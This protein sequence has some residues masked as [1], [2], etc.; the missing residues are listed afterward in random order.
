MPADGPAL[1]GQTRFSL[2]GF[3]ATTSLVVQGAGAGKEVPL[4]ATLDAAG[5]CGGLCCGRSRR[6]VQLRDVT[7]WSLRPHSRQLLLQLRAGA[8]TAVGMLLPR[9]Q[10]KAVAEALGLA[11]EEAHAAA[12]VAAGMTAPSAR[13]EDAQEPLV[14]LVESHAANVCGAYRYDHL[15]VGMGFPGALGAT[16]VRTSRSK[17][18]S[19]CAKLGLAQARDAVEG[20]RLDQVRWLASVAPGAGCCSVMSS[21]TEAGGRSVKEYVVLGVEDGATLAVAVKKGESEGILN[22]LRVRLRQ[23]AYAGRAGFSKV[24]FEPETLKRELLTT[25]TCACCG[26][27]GQLQVTSHSIVARRS[28]CPAKCCAAC[29]GE[30]TVVLPIGE[31]AVVSSVD[32][33][34]CSCARVCDAGSLMTKNACAVAAA[35]GELNCEAVACSLCLEGLLTALWELL[36]L[37][38][39]CVAPGWRS[40]SFLVFAGAG[41]SRDV[42]LRV[43]PAGDAEGTTG[44]QLAADLMQQLAALRFEREAEATIARGVLYGRAKLGGGGASFGGGGAGSSASSDSASASARPVV[45]LLA[46]DGE[47]AL[48]AA[49][50]ASRDAAAPLPAGALLEEAAAAEAEAERAAVGAGTGK[51]AGTAARSNPFGDA[52]PAAGV[53]V[54]VMLPAESGNSVFAANVLDASRQQM[55]SVDGLSPLGAVSP[56]GLP[57]DGTAEAPAATAAAASAAGGIVAVTNP[58]GAAVAAAAAE[59]AASSSASAEAPSAGRPPLVPVTAG[60]GG[61]AVVSSN[62]FFA[63]GVAASASAPA[64]ASALAPASASASA[65]AG[66]AAAVVTNTFHEAASNSDESAATATPH[67]AAGARPASTRTGAS[68]GAADGAS[69][70]ATAGAAAPLPKGWEENVDGDDVWYTNE[71][72]G[73]SLWERPT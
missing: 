65:A 49:P 70:S 67:H 36:L 31:V 43:R 72:T 59:G 55:A 47:E 48:A 57:V 13:K 34:S 42:R 66:G 54:S 1:A 22:A 52:A 10:G 51:G 24:N 50:S 61:A 17:Q 35:V 25:S 46:S 41:R 15:Q 23:Q 68:A 32:E 39:S 11:I 37:A 71:E 6:I 4:T 63:A 69:A 56:V 73:E 5:A 26:P 8:A 19:C 60:D 18:A 33:C 3:F 27:S 38:L 44:A 28:Q 40:S 29:A 16:A 9:H 14:S 12:A 20:A 45:D 64:S 2:S 53:S 62:P 21:P 30:E 58:F 7:S